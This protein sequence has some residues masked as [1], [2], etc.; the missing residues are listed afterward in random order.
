MYY[1]AFAVTGVINVTTLDD[2]LVSLVEEERHIDAILINVSAYEGNMVEG[3]I[4]TRRVLEIRDEVFDTEEDLGAANFPYSTSK[5][6]R[7][8]VDQDIPKGQI[9]KIGINCGG[10]A[11]DIRGAYEYTIKA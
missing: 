9:F 11:S 1:K 8:P 6:G 3:W 7:L 5:I 10:V 4:G 2:G